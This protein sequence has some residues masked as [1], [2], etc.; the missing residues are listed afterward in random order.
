MTTRI[1]TAG[2][3]PHAELIRDI[4][5]ECVNRRAGLTCEQELMQR[6][7][8]PLLV[9]DFLARHGPLPSLRMEG[10]RLAGEPTIV[11]ASKTPPGAA[12]A[13]PVLPP[14][15]RRYDEHDPQWRDS[16]AP[17]PFE[18]SVHDRECAINSGLRQVRAAAPL[19]QMLRGGAIAAGVAFSVALIWLMLDLVSV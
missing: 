8:D 17:S 10:Q 7:G 2:C 19:T 14:V 13:T 1:E 5:K 15:S 3:P 9:W 18:P 16:L 11:L 6:S 12:P 4:G